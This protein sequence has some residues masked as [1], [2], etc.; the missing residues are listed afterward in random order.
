MKVKLRNKLDDAGRGERAP[1]VEGPSRGPGVEP[2]SGGFSSAPQAGKERFLC[3]F[4]INEFIID[5]HDIFS[6]KNKR[7][8][9]MHYFILLF[10]VNDRE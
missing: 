8:R 7:I 1:G 6:R 5:F 9:V 4:Q 2:F 10:F 3:L